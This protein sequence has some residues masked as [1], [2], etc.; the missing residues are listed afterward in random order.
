MRVRGVLAVATL[1][2]AL[3]IAAA[4]AAEPGFATVKVNLRTGPD[5]DFPS[6]GTIPEG[7]RLHVEGC[8]HDKSWC[9]VRWGQE[10]GWIYGEYVDFD[11]SGKMVPLPDYGAKYFHVPLVTFAARDYWNRYYVGRPWYADRDRWFAYQWRARPDWHAPPS[12]QRQ[13]GWWRPGYV[14]PP[15]ISP[16]PGPGWHPAHGTPRDNPHNDHN[17][18]HDDRHDE[19]HNDGPGPGP[20]EGH[21]HDHDRHEHVHDRHHDHHGKRHHG[22]H[23]KHGQHGHGHRHHKHAHHG[24]GHHHHK[25]GHHGHHGHRR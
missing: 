10:R 3:G 17:R 12:G 19:R 5:T 25:H 22:H 8:L 16:P 4:H 24:H 13:P 23:H 1:M 6:I 2:A 20:V 14:P 15:G 11:Q 7:E 18:R 21:D 9:D